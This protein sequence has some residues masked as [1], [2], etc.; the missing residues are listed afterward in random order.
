MLQEIIENI[1]ASSWGRADIEIA[2][3]LVLRKLISED[4]RAVGYACADV[5]QVQSFPPQI[6]RRRGALQRRAIADTLELEV[7]LN[8]VRALSADPS[9]YGLSTHF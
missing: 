5:S 8:T 6:C 1:V 4:E 7:E 2:L 9:I 3:E